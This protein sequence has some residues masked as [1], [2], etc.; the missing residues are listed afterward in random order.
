MLLRVVQIDEGGGPASPPTIRVAVDGGDATAVEPT[1]TVLGTQP[2]ARAP[3]AIA[4]LRSEADAIQ[5]VEIELVRRGHAWSLRIDN[6]DG[7]DH[8][9]TWV[10]ASTGAETLQPW[11]DVPTP[12][13]EL[14][15]PAGAAAADLTLVNYGPGPLVLTDPDG[16]DLGEGFRLT[17][18]GAHSVAGNQRTTARI[19]FM[20]APPATATT[21][22]AFASN[23]PAAG[24]TAGHRNQVTLTADY[25]AW[26][27]GAILA[28]T[29]DG[30]CTLDR[31]TGALTSVAP[32]LAGA[33]DVAVD[34]TTGDALVLGSDLVRVDRL[35]G[36]RVGPPGCRD[37]SPPS[38]WS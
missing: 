27:P 16:A 8:R 38:G 12:T 23:D 24:S 22:H 36:K 20:P 10:V 11:L 31:P 2:G 13:L 18:L 7:R 26:R 9:Y 14:P 37:S 19:A 28:V 30:L 32:S 25:F 34:P 6:T 17:G 3:I 33:G 21:V 5:L 15:T 1:P 4:T 29:A 35:T